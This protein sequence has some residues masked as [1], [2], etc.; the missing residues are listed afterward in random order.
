METIMRKRL[1]FA[2]GSNINLDQMAGRCPNA[3]PIMPVTLR[4]YALS[5]RGMSGVAT[6]LPKKGA[7]VHGLLWD[8][9]PICEQSLDRYEGYPHLYNKES[10]VVVNE[11]D[12]TGYRVM[13]YIMAPAHAKIPQEPTSWYFN[14]ILD[15]YRQNGIP[16]QPLYEALHTTRKDI[17]A[18]EALN[19]RSFRQ[20]DFNWQQNKGNI[21]PHKPKNKGR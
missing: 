18:L 13:A 11:K 4:G 1:Y 15:G 17:A 5:F 2:Y 21:K 3:V 12:N 19:N 6:I 20:L 8:L 9:T 10:V 16:I 7:K 14:G